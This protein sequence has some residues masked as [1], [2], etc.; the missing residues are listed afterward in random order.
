MIF[1]NACFPLDDELQA[2]KSRKNQPKYH[3]FWLK[4]WWK[5]DKNR[6]RIWSSIPD[7]CWQ[8]FLTILGASGEPFGRLGGSFGRPWALIGVSFALSWRILEP[9]WFL[10]AILWA[11]LDLQNS[12]WRPPGLILEPLGTNFVGQVEWQSIIYQG[13]AECAKRLNI[14]H[15]K[16]S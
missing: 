7:T 4:I 5:I 15:K 16:Y 12:F 14:N 13:P 3:I 8:L 6:Y 11:I 2:K 1:T 9:S 10:L